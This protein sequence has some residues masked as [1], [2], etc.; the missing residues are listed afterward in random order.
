MITILLQC[1]DGVLTSHHSWVW[2]RLMFPKKKKV[3]QPSFIANILCLLC[4]E[5]YIV[6]YFSSPGE[7]LGCIRKFP[8]PPPP[9]PP[10][11]FKEWEYKCTKLYF[12]TNC[13]RNLCIILQYWSFILYNYV[14]ILIQHM[15]ISMI[16]KRKNW[17]AH[18]IFIMTVLIRDWTQQMPV[19]PR[20][21]N[22]L[23]RPVREKA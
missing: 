6:K 7:G 4:R 12:I 23:V 17:I 11:T 5:H 10:L 18:S 13:D 19:I 20:Y 3:E 22:S 9:P 1:P 2:I 16:F 15:L 8:P 21:C 14:K